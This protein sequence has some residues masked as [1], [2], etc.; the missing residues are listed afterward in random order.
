MRKISWANS[1][2]SS[3]P[4][5]ARISSTTS[6]SSLRIF[7]QQQNLQILLDLRQGR[8][9]PL[10]LQPRHLLHF[11]IG[12]GQHGL[13]LRQLVGILLVIAILRDDLAEIAVRLGDF[14]VRLAVG[15]HSRIGHLR[16][17]FFEMFFDLVE[18]L[19]ILH[20]DLSDHQ[21]AA[22]GGFERHRAVESLDRHLGLFV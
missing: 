6:F 20:G 11:R 8:L 7:R 4:V 1:E 2:A 22:L 10:D 18:L 15:N 14:T 13:C 17:Q 21:F 19:R 5:P 16:G 3:P 12:L 9:Q